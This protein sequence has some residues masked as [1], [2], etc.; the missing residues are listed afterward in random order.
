M[1]EAYA[2]KSDRTAA[3]ALAQKD[4][5]TP[6]FEKFL[7]RHRSA[8]FERAKYAYAPCCEKRGGT[9]GTQESTSYACAVAFPL[10][11]PMSKEQECEH[12]KALNYSPEA[13]Q[14]GSSSQAIPEAH[15]AVV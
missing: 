8:C 11:R 7:I 13:G 9:H 1:T 5:A 6:L 14:Y 3:S 15:Q 4:K 2:L 12:D 10:I